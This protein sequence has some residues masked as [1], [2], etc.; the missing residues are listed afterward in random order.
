[1]IH[2]W[3]YARRDNALFYSIGC[4]SLVHYEI[5]RRRANDRRNQNIPD[6]RVH[7]FVPVPINFCKFEKNSSK[8]RKSFAVWRKSENSAQ[9]G[10]SKAKQSNKKKLY[11]FCMDMIWHVS[12]ESER[13]N[14]PM[15][16]IP[17]L[18]EFEAQRI[19]HSRS[20]RYDR[21]HTH[22]GTHWICTATNPHSVARF[23]G[24]G[25]C[26]CG[27]ASQL[28]EWTRIR[29]QVTSLIWSR[30]NESRRIRFCL[31]LPMNCI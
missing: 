30:W 18:I 16:P 6:E 25:R 7:L 10:R 26:C 8:W 14:Y 29:E 4:R 19:F 11:Q 5:S 27:V 2:V 23:K 9:S 28:S 22:A 12:W 17:M 31:T 15:I 20:L 13:S 21:R 1:M 24:N 3:K